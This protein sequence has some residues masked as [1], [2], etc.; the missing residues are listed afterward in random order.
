MRQ[1][2][3][4]IMLLSGVYL[5][6]GL[7]APLFSYFQSSATETIYK[8]GRTLCVQRPSRCLW[9]LNDHTALCGKCMGIYSG[10]LLMGL[11]RIWRRRLPDKPVWALVGLLIFGLTAAH[12]IYRALAG[13]W[14]PPVWL[15]FVMGLAAAAGAIMVINY[16]WINGRGLLMSILVKRWWV[17]AA[18]VLLLNL[19]GASVALATEKIT[20]HAGTPVILEVSTGFS[21][22]E[23]QEGESVSLLVLR[24]VR[25][26]GEIL[27]RRG[28]AARAKVVKSKAAS[29]WGSG[30]ECA[31]EVRS[32][33]A[34]DGSEI[35][36]G[37]RASR[38]GDNDHGAATAL[39][40]GAGI[41]CLPFAAV[42]FA[43]KGEEGNFPPGY[44][45]VAHVDGDYK[46]RILSDHQQKAIQE[47]QDARAKRLSE[48]F[49]KRIEKMRKEKKEQMESSGQNISNDP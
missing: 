47:E 39:G 6:I 32:V 44:E 33:P 30:G 26:R 18:L 8:L 23:V 3:V 19:W 28:V 41:I 9:F 35:L 4:F 1:F 11:F 16:I 20:L 5:M 37:G 36:L 22:D 43:V 17:V 49:N 46:V 45:I 34:V 31:I 29:G 24:P 40:V 13:G 27:I 25:V 21:S 42:G 10:V 14:L 15:S 12:S 48:D 7:S 38:R 2:L